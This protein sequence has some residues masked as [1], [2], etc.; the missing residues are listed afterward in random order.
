MDFILTVGS[1]HSRV[2]VQSMT[3]YQHV[4]RNVNMKLFVINKQILIFLHYHKNGV[5]M[6]CG[7]C[8]ADVSKLPVAII[9]QVLSVAL[10]QTCDRS[11]PGRPSP[12]PPPP[13]RSYR[14]QRSAPSRPG[15]RQDIYEERRSRGASACHPSP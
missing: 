15:R 10:I 14:P 5:K 3:E 2:K 12:P 11:S 4:L 8:V 6:L 1:G 13:P 7:D 9:A